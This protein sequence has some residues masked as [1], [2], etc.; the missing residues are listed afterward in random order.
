MVNYAASKWEYF[1]SAYWMERLV[2]YRK[3]IL[4]SFQTGLLAIAYLVSYYMRFEGHIPAKFVKIMLMTLPPIVFVQGTLSIYFGL[5]RGLWRYMS[6]VDSKIIIRVMV[7]S[8][9]VTFI[10]EFFWGPY[11]GYMPRSI[12]FLDFLC[13]VALV[14]GARLMMRYLREHDNLFNNVPNTCRVML[15]GPLE[16]AEPLLREMNQR[17]G[18]YPV[19]LLEPGQTFRGRNI[20]GIPIIGGLQK[21]QAVIERYT[22]QEIIIVWPEAQ[23]DKFNDILKQSKYCNIK[24]KVVPSLAQVLDG[25]SRLADARD[26]EIE[27]L[28]PRPPIHID[29]AIIQDSIRDHVAL[30]T[31]GGGSIGSELCRQLADFGVKVLVLLD[32]AENTLYE[33]ELALRR[34]FPNLN[35]LSQVCSINDA[36]GLRICLRQHKPDIIFHAAAYKHVPLME[37]CPIEAAYNNVIG[38]RNLVKAA[39]AEGIQRFI[40]IS[41]D[42]A[43]NPTSVMGVSKRITEKYVQA[44]NVLNKT[45]FI[46]TRFGNVLGSAGSVI[47]I[48]KAQLAQGGPITVTHPE[49]ERYFMT[50]K[51]AAQLVLQAAYKGR[52]GEIFVLKMGR[53][54]KIRD[55]AEKIIA[56]SGNGRSKI[57]IVYTGIRPGEKLSEELFNDDEI[58]QPTDHPHLSCALGVKSHL[59]IL[60]KQ[61]DHV[62]TLVRLRDVPGLIEQFKAIVPNYQPDMKLF[63]AE[64]GGSLAVKEMMRPMAKSRKVNR[65]QNKKPLL[66]KSMRPELNEFR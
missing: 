14:S 5:H 66:R 59:E 31:G 44:S 41:T 47:P 42:K 27:D 16:A 58:Q 38:T 11:I 19:A 52:A 29:R 24:C 43:V 62:Q 22:V 46:I 12:Y 1:H 55:L 34:S 64:P 2:P 63:A 45:E 37:R 51:E 3:V 4:A 39:I 21:L 18:Y 30:V 17:N 54:V 36:L 48:F 65:S 15:I 7:I 49:I 20:H 25:Q 40:M 26:I 53:L 57:D 60:E 50:I 35:L 33:T 56:L 8:L 32:R 10:M 23:P 9:F 28:L 13:A 6:F 61:L